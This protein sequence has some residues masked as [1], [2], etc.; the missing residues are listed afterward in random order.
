MHG[1][2][3]RQ[4]TWDLHS[5]SGWYLGTSTEHYPC[6]IIF[7]KKTRSERIS[8]TVFFR[9]RYT[10]QLTVTPKDQ[11]IKTVGDLSSALRQRV[12]AQGKEEMAVLKKMNDILTNSSSKPV[13]LKKTVTFR[14]P[15]PKPRV[16]HQRMH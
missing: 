13:E 5:L 2:T 9:H 3:N 15:I 8:N 11:K 6:H 10:T 14:D 4:K 7:C 16:G 12:N 1:S